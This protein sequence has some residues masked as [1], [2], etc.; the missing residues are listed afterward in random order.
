MGK[1]SRSR[2]LEVDPARQRI[3]LDGTFNFRDIGGYRAVGGRR[4]KKGRIY[5]SDNLSR[6]EGASQEQLARMNIRLVCDFR[7]EP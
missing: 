2:E 5:R 3:A 1:E 7:S 6:L 4:V